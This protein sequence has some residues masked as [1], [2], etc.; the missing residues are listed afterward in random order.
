MIMKILAQCPFCLFSF[1]LP[2]DALDKRT[3]CQKCRHM[4]KIPHPDQVNSAIEKL[5]DSKSTIYIDLKGN[6][7]A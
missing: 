7:Y 6:T 4:F 3:R 2:E 1:E 5:K